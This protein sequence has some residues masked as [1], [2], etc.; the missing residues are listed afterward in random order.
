MCCAD[1]YGAVALLVQALDLAGP[2]QGL[3]HLWLLGHDLLVDFAHQLQQRAVQGHF[4]F[5]HERHGGRELRADAVGADE[6][7]GGHR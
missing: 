4:L 1:A 2:A 7:V 6:I 3:G 5:V